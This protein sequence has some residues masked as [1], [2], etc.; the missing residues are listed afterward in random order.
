MLENDKC[1]ERLTKALFGE[2]ISKDNGIWVYSSGGPKTIAMYSLPNESMFFDAG[3]S[4]PVIPSS[5]RAPI[6][7]WEK[8]DMYPKRGEMAEYGRLARDWNKASRP[9][10]T[11]T[12]LLGAD[13]FV[14]VNQSIALDYRDTRDICSQLLSLSKVE[15]PKDTGQRAGYVAF[16]T[17][18]QNRVL[19]PTNMDLVGS[20]VKSVWYGTSGATNLAELLLTMALGYRL[21]KPVRFDNYGET[22]A[23]TTEGQREMHLFA[24]KLDKLLDLKI[25]LELTS[26]DEK[27][28]NPVD[29]S[30]KYIALQIENTLGHPVGLCHTPS[31]V[32]IMTNTYEWLE[33]NGRKTIRELHKEGY[34]FGGAVIYWAFYAKAKHGN[35]PF[36][37]V[38]YDG[39]KGAVHQLA[40]P[41]MEPPHGLWIA[42][43]GN[44]KILRIDYKDPYEEFNIPH[45]L[46]TLE[47]SNKLP[48]A[49]TQLWNLAL[50]RVPLAP[51][52]VGSKVVVLV[53]SDGS[54]N[55][56]S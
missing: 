3:K 6:S 53:Q 34:R 49:L 21:K 2:P 41:W 29:S 36:C 33:K 28:L 40:K 37:A 16:T 48:E 1:A 12:L 30:V 38:V 43:V 19:Y 52:K 10:L 39:S 44:F 4:K 18:P 11:P 54:L 7:I 17:L 27:I 50:E 51:K 14:A 55:V 15:L 26:T 56:E 23:R 42:P 8:K 46:Q 45:F 20:Q 22:L 24:E 32:P 9:T 35:S 47:E 5:K 25:K 13:I 31:G